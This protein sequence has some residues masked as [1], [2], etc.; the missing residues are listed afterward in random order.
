[1][2]RWLALATLVVIAG[3]GIPPAHADSGETPPPDPAPGTA[4]WQLRDAQ[5]MA[6]A[7]G[8]LTMDQ[9][10]NL[11]YQRARDAALPGTYGAGLSRQ[12]ADP[13]RPNVT[14]AQLVPGATN[15]DPFRLDWA[16]R[17][18]G[19]QTPVTFLNRFSTATAQTPGKISG[20]PTP[21][22]GWTVT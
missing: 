14:A 22:R 16:E 4:E 13:S 10:S 12:L 17:G 2:R 21:G 3:L 19:V 18:R 9:Y 20:C 11:A 1:M 7:M 15:A 8:R 6:H 5:N